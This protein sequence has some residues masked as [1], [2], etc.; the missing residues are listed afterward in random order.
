MTV[1]RRPKGLEVVPRAT[2]RRS[3]EWGA[4]FFVID[5]TPSPPRATP[6][7]RNFSG[8]RFVLVLNNVI[9][10]QMIFSLIH[11]SAAV[12]SMPLC[13]VW[14]ELRR[15][16]PIMGFVGSGPGLVIILA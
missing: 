3:E 2:R 11:P 1:K 16:P 9:F 14:L 12:W 15:L 6:N 4:C 5:V 8:T 13:R 10:D 7:Y